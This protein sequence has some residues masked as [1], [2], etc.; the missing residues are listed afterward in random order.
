MS[1][2]IIL[3]SLGVII[4][5][6]FWIWMGILYF[7]KQTRRDKFRRYKYEQKVWSQFG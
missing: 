1:L 4:S 2:E 7:R 5:V 3:I 6:G